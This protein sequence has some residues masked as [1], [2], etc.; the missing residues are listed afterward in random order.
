MCEIVK[1]K[2]FFHSYR[3]F[4]EALVRCRNSP[5]D[6]G[7]LMNRYENKFE[8]Y[9]KYFQ[10]KPVSDHIVTMHLLY[11][12]KIRQNLGSRLDVSV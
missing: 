9:N 6:L 11:F 8:M 3:S 2:N 12:D 10:N 4:L 7:P 1:K 5:S